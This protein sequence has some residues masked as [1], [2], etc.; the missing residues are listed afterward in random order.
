MN[1][2]KN[3][4]ASEE[5]KY[6]HMQDFP[7]VSPQRTLDIWNNDCDHKFSQLTTL[8]R[9]HH[10]LENLLNSCW[11][12]GIPVIPAKLTARERPNMAYRI[13]LRDHSPAIIIGEKYNDPSQLLYALAH[14]LSS[15]NQGLSTADPIR[16]LPFCEGVHSHVF[17]SK[18]SE[19]VNLAHKESI[20]FLTKGR[21]TT[22][23]LESLKGE[24]DAGKVALACIHE[25]QKVG[26]NPGVI[27][28]L[29]A[30]RFYAFDIVSDSLDYLVLENERGLTERKYT[31]IN[32]LI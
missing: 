7:N 29:I 2:L 14:A 4:V 20:N 13:E 31:Q 1:I 18:Q 6:H 24:T 8:P 28:L 26:V 25:G 32:N 5:Y 11:Q 12:S 27:A 9:Q 3:E 30:D 23:F 16:M 17:E 22:N 19:Q 10:S 15:I 21:V